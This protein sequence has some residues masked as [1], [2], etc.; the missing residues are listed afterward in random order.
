MK[1]IV[2][3][4]LV[5]TVVVACDS[6]VTTTEQKLDS[7]GDKIETVAGRAWD[8]T[9]AKGK[10]LKDKVEDKLDKAGDSV[11]KKQDSIDRKN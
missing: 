4:L 1:K 6:N 2:G 5:V 10:E 8:S 3:L 9:K 11:N 7:L